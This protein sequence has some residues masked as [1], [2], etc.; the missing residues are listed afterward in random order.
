VVSEHRAS[1]E[2]KASVFVS[3]AIDARPRHSP[4]LAQPRL[5]VPGDVHGGR[6][7]SDVVGVVVGEAPT[8]APNG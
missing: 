4:P 6:Y 7:V 5:I 2:K 1:G 3:E 8:Q